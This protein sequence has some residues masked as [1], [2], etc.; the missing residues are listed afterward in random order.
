MPTGEIGLRKPGPL[1]LTRERDDS[2]TVYDPDQHA[3]LRL[4]CGKCLGCKKANAKAWAL[5][6]HLELQQHRQAAFTTLTYDNKSLPPTL[7]KRHLQLWLKK[8]RRRSSAAGAI[9]F[10]ASGEYGE[11]NG[12]PH[13]HAIIYGRGAAAQDEFEEAWGKGI[14]R[15]YDVT[16]NMI[17]YVAGYTAEK[18]TADDGREHERVDPETGEVFTWVPPF[19]QMSRKPGIGGDARKHINSWRMYAIHQGHKMPVPRFLHEAWKKQ[20]TEEELEALLLEKKALTRNTSRQTLAAEEQIRT[21]RLKIDN[22]KRK[23]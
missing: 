16:P 21:A 2:I 12:R 13:Y 10:F 3:P 6:C 4:P 19:R 22:S 1:R 11:T 7:E 14:V 9:R 17:A 15:T 20:A 18:Y 8:L 23:L 5:R